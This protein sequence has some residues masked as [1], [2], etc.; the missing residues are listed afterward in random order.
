MQ[1]LISRLLSILPTHLMA[2]GLSQSDK[3][4]IN[5]SDVLETGPPSLH[6]SVPLQLTLFQTHSL[7]ADQ[8]RAIICKTYFPSQPAE[9][10]SLWI[11]WVGLTHSLSVTGW[12]FQMFLVSS[13]IWFLQVQCTNL[14]SVSR[15]V[16]HR[17][18]WKCVTVVK[19]LKVG[20]IIKHPT[21]NMFLTFRILW[22]QYIFTLIPVLTA[23]LHSKPHYKEGMCWDGNSGLTPI[24]N[25]SLSVMMLIRSYLQNLEISSRD[26]WALLW[27]KKRNMF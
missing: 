18:L 20:N 10:P 12:F 21:S 17:N 4:G 2:F 25:I 7:F 8:L 13:N 5:V 27:Q 3:W 26:Q 16:A 1:N 24:S 19:W 9:S 14:G 6:P 23:H 11:Q 15:M 22:R